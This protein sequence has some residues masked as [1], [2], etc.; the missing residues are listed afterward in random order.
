MVRPQS[1][2]TL[3]V[4][5]WPIF[6]VTRS[7]QRAQV[8][9]AHSGHPL[10]SIRLGFFA[11]RPLKLLPVAATLAVGRIDADQRRRERAS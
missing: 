6:S 1:S 8:R 11:E 5:T 7:P 2:S 4:T 9:G 3:K 10:E